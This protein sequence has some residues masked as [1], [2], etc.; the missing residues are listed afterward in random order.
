MKERKIEERSD[1]LKINGG[2]FVNQGEAIG[3]YGKDN[4]KILVVGNPANTNALIGKN[5]ANKD[6]QLWMAMT[7]LDSSRAKSVISK[8]TGTNID[9]R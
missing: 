3:K 6:S 7:M 5:A 9:K 1:L 8:K 2:I 4:A